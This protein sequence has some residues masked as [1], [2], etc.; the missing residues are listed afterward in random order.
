MRRTLNVIQV[1]LVIAIT[2]LT[3]LI[4]LMGNEDSSTVTKKENELDNTQRPASGGRQ[5]SKASA[6]DFDFETY[7]QQRLSALTDSAQKAYLS[8]SAS[9]SGTS[10]TAEVHNRVQFW[11]DQSRPALAGYFQAQ[12]AQ[13]VGSPKAWTRAGQFFQEARKNADD[14]VV[15]QASVSKAAG[16]FKKAL[17]QAPDNLKAKSGLAITYI[18]GKQ[19]V[20]KGVS[21]LKEVVDQNPRNR[22]A[23]F[24]LGMLS[25]RSGQYEKA[26]SRFNKLVEI[27]PQNPFNHLYLGN[28]HEQLGD[29]SA[30]LEEFRKY[31]KLVQQPKLKANAEEK[32][33]DLKQSQKN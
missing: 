33:N 16:C 23:L 1:V 27:Q 20:M 29:K 28:V 31:Q 3:L 6:A 11:K 4:F 13:K 17:N 7:K 22:K 15:Q 9:G 26:K 5:G 24:Y 21:L 30:A 8:L 32:I 2:G 19:Q 10:D 25:I 18:E 14:T 12:L